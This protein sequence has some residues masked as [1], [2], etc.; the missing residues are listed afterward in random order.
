MII[1]DRILKTTSLS[2]Q[3][4]RKLVS[5]NLLAICVQD[6]VSSDVCSKVVDKL[7]SCS[8][9]EHYNNGPQAGRIGPAYIEVQSD[10]EKLEVYEKKA[11]SW[12]H[13]IRNVFSPFLSPMD[14]LRLELDEIWPTGCQPWRRHPLVVWS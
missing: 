4:F 3:D 11:I 13:E 14:K 7:L 6:Y 9:Y 5:G 2:L 1:D 8:L 10:S 12:I